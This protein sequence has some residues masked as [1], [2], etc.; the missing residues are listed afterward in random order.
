M[1]YHLSLLSIICNDGRWLR[2]WL[3]YYLLLGV[4]HFYLYDHKST[5]ETDSVLLPYILKGQVTYTFIPDEVPLSELDSLLCKYY[6]EGLELA[7]KETRWLAIVDPDEFLVPLQ[8]KNLPSLLISYEKYGGLA[9]N[10]QVFGTSGIEKLPLH[11][12]L[13]QSLFRKAPVRHSLNQ[14]VKLI[15]QPL[16]VKE[17]KTPREAVYEEEWFTVDTNHQKV[18]GGVNPNIPVNVLQVNH[19]FTRDR[20]YFV[21]VKVPRRAGY[22]T[23]PFVVVQWES[24]MNAVT[25]GSIHRF[26]PL[27]KKKLEFDRFPLHYNWEFYVGM[28]P[29]LVKMGIDTEEKAVAHWLA[30]GEKERRISAFNWRHYLS[31]NI[32]LARSGINTEALALKHWLARGRYERRPL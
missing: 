31:M 29:D 15:L 13:V 9:V 6:N 4:E 7:R 1:K 27:L 3:E 8:T 32:D 14:H 25:D 19:Y 21:K 17:L 2:E 28:Y 5:D 10:W 11:V 23:D 20:D 26:V 12:S 30:Y 24:E 18:E 16:R 22:G